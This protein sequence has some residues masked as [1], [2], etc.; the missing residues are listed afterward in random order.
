M[1]GIRWNVRQTRPP[2]YLAALD[3]GSLPAGTRSVPAARSAA[4]E[5]GRFSAA[6]P[7]R[8]PKLLRA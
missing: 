7:A 8:S 6:R 4:T 2:I 3:V 1:N 5:S